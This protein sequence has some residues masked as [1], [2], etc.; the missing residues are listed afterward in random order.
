MARRIT[1]TFK[2]TGASE[3]PMDMLRYDAVY[4]RTSEDASNIGAGQWHKRERRTIEIKG[5]GC[6]PDRW[7]SFGWKVSDLFDMR[8]A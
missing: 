3:F 6:T 4:P 8:I 1:K 5:E 2:V 7:A